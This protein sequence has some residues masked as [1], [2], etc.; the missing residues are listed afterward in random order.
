LT[1]NA[2]LISPVDLDLI[3]DDYDDDEEG[4]AFFIELQSRNVSK[5]AALNVIYRV[6]GIDVGHHDGADDWLQDP[7]ETSIHACKF[8]GPQSW[9]PKHSLEYSSDALAPSEEHNA[10][11][12]CR[13]PRLKPDSIWRSVPKEQRVH[14]FCVGIV[15]AL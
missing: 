3:R 15:A 12:W 14:Q 5:V 10:K 4:V 2:R 8:A 6:S 11:R 13:I 9:K 7:I 1:L